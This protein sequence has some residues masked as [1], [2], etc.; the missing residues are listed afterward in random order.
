MLGRIPS[1]EASGSTSST[2]HSTAGVQQ[3]TTVH[4]SPPF[5]TFVQQ[6]NNGGPHSELSTSKQVEGYLEFNFLRAAGLIVARGVQLATQN[7]IRW[8]RA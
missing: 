3:H 5:S 1:T 4:V 6:F 8:H 7:S 2:W